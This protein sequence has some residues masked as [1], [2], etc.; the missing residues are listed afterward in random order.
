MEF[1]EAEACVDFALER[2]GNELNIATP[3]GLGK[4]NQLLNAFYR[5]AATNPD[6]QLQI[7]TA[8]SLTDVQGASRPK[9]VFAL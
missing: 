6:I 5:R 3:L 4:P 9:S 8:L 1:S 2:L 7:L